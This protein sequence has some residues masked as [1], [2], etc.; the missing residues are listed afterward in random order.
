[1]SSHFEHYYTPSPK[2]ELRKSE[3]KL[4]LR[5]GHEYQFITPSGVFS[6]GHVD[7]ASR[8]LIEYAKIH[9]KSLLDIGCGY[10]VVGITLAKENPLID[11]SMSDVNSRAVEFTKINAKNHNIQPN[12][13]IGYLYTPWNKQ[14]FDMILSNPPMAAGKEVWMELISKAHEHLNPGGSI[15]IVAFHN[16]GGERLMNYLR[17]V[18]GN[19]RT[20]V[21]SGGIRVYFSCKDG[22]PF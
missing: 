15:Q 3:A 8:I 17:S 12:I 11:L 18:M 4:L 1:M 5:N 16:K 14:R 2:S 20:L 9:G 22:N 6:F 21:K 13:A 19:V 7:R 10:G